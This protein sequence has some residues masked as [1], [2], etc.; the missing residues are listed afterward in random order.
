MPE[1]SSFAPGTPSWVD[2]STTDPVAAREFYGPLFGWEFDVSD[3]EQTGH[4]AMVIKAGRVVA[5]IN[6]LPVTEHPPAWATYF[7]TDDVQK[8]SELVSENG[9]ANIL[10]PMPVGPAGSMLIWQ[11]PTGAFAGAWQAGEHPGA[12]L[13]DEPG[14][15]CW[16]EL[17]TRDLDASAAFYSAILPVNVHDVSEGNFQYRTLQVD[18]RDVA[19]MWLMTADIPAGVPPHWTVYFAVENTDASVSR[20]LELG[21]ASVTEAMDSPYGRFAL[22]RDPQGAGFNVIQAPAGG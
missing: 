14:T 13:V 12:Q 11:D 8:L 4:Y 5:G 18:G 16:N 6:G 9:G 1:R 19:G 3:D 22:L 2:L 17:N 10:G 21:G 15:L 20:A 7:A